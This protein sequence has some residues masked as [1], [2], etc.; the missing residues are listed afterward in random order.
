MNHE[1]DKSNVF[2]FIIIFIPLILVTIPT[3]FI[4][5]KNY[6][7]DISF[8]PP[9]IVFSIVWPILLILLGIS[10]YIFIISYTKNSHFFII[11]TLFIILI[12][13]LASWT[14]MYKY[15]KIGGLI[16]IIISFCIVL[17]LIINLFLNKSVTAVTSSV[18]IIPLAGWLIFAGILN[19]LS[20]N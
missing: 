10:W 9:P 1:N 17:Y 20:I 7:K 18:L 19:T 15:S 5:M 14:I 11:Q 16:N 6:G 2:L 4:D 8:R 13:L 3:L 12:L